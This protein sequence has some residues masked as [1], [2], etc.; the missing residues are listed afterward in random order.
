VTA[1]SNDNRDSTPKDS[2]DDHGDSIGQNEVNQEII[3][4]LL[5]SDAE[6]VENQNLN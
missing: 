6:D 1:G 2:F 5:Q 3:E 4:Y